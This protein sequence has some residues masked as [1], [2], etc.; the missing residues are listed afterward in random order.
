[1]R[2]AMATRAEV[3]RILRHVIEPVGSV[4]ATEGASSSGKSTLCGA[5]QKRLTDL[6]GLQGYVL[7]SAGTRRLLTGI[8]R[9]WAE[10]LER[11]RGRTGAGGVAERRL[12]LGP[13]NEN[14]ATGKSRAQVAAHRDPRQ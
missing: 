13:C 8:H 9:R 4:S 2:C 14:S 1:M 12:W 10:H 5:F 11:G 3:I 6:V 7:P